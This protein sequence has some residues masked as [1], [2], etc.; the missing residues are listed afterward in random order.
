[1]KNLLLNL[2]IFLIA[3]FS[4]FAQDNPTSA[5][6]EEETIEKT[7]SPESYR[8]ALINMQSAAGTEAVYNM[9]IVQI[10]EM[11][12]QE[13][14][15]IL[16]AEILDEMKKEFSSSAYDD[17]TEL[18]IPVYKKYLTEK[19]LNDIAAFYKTPSGKK[20]A[21]NN[22]LIVQESMDI[23]SKW[24]AEIAEKIISKLEEA[25]EDKK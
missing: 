15:S 17:L 18:L 14:S 24:G 6:K 4:L 2:T 25:S 1:M 10:F 9:M 16:D 22:P 5:Q 12:E 11:Y 8:D 3:S 20:L 7:T 19:E 13:F 21:E 23:G